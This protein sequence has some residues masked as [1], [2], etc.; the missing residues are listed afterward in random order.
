MFQPKITKNHKK[1]CKN[2]NNMKQGTVEYIHGDESNNK[3][4][5]V[6]KYKNCKKH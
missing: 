1:I 6:K 4:S 2:K 5:K 3:Y